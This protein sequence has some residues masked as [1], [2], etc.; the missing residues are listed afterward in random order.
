MTDVERGW[1]IGQLEQ[2]ERLWQPLLRSDASAQGGGGGAEGG[3]AE[4]G[5]GGGGGGGSGGGGGAL[6]LST[7]DDLLYE[8]A[9]VPVSF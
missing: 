2:A 8:V 5:G 1:L 6:P 9:K 7:V 4:G 3:G